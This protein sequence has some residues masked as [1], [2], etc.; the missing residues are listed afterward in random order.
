MTP[1]PNK[2]ASPEPPLDVSGSNSPVDQTLDS[3][4]VPASG[5]GR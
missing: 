1:L 4:P 5:G 3:L 2:I